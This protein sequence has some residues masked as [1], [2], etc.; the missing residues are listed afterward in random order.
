MTG[1]ND[2]TSSDHY[3]FFLDV[4]SE[5]IT[6]PQAISTPSPFERKLNSKSPQAIR[7]Y[8]QYLQKR[9]IN[10]FNFELEKRLCPDIP[11]H[12]KHLFRIKNGYLN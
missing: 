12:D 3:G 1:F 7:T 10:K 8:K 5:A 2:I 6:N 4:Q 9:C 11:E